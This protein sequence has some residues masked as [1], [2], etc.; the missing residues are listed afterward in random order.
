M[1]IIEAILVCLIILIHC[2]L[3]HAGG[4]EISSGKKYCDTV[5]T[6]LHKSSEFN[7]ILE[8]D[9]NGTYLGRSI[10][11]YYALF[12]Y[13]EKLELL[14]NNKSLSSSDLDEALI[15]GVFSGHENIVNLLLDNDVSANTME[16]ESGSSV[17]M[18]AAQCEREEITE[19]LLSYNADPNYELENGNNALIAAFVNQNEKIVSILINAGANISK[20]SDTPRGSLCDLAFK[21]QAREMQYYFCKESKASP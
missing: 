19:L 2:S 12:G 9:A 16:G 3:A 4:F 11:Y 14:V 7:K 5:V 18:I 15:A 10:A 13:Y 21:S 20:L 8:Q 6:N 17:L 1:K